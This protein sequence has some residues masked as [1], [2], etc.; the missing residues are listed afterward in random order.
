[1]VIWRVFPYNGGDFEEFPEILIICFCLPPTL[2]LPQR[3]FSMFSLPPFF[4][5]LQ[6]LGIQS[7]SENGSGAENIV[8]FGG[9]WTPQ[10]SFE[11][12]VDGRNP[13]NQLIGSLSHYLQGFIHPRWCRIPS[14]PGEFLSTCFFPLVQGRVVTWRPGAEGPSGYWPCWGLNPE[15]LPTP[16]KESALSGGGNSNMFGIFTPKIWEDEPILTNICFKWVEGNHQL[17]L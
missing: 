12:T 10:S 9:D 6:S 16:Q 8:F 1:M 4:F 14:M 13:A 11:N 7:P 15:K 17:V 3:F 5:G 2:P